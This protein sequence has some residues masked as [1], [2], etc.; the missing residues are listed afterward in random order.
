MLRS[1][2]KKVSSKIL[3]SN[4][5]GVLA[6]WILLLATVIIIPQGSLYSGLLPSAAYAQQSE[7][8]EKQQSQEQDGQTSDQARDEST[9]DL[10]VEIISP[11]GTRG[12][13]PATFEFEANVTGGTEPYTLRWDFDDGSRA[14]DKETVEHTFDEAG[15]YNVTLNATDADDQTASDSLKIVI[16]AASAQ[17]DESSSAGDL[18]GLPGVSDV[19]GLEEG[20]KGLPGLPGLGGTDENPP[21]GGGGTDEN[22]PSGGG[23]TDENPPSDNSGQGGADKFGIDEIYPTASNGPVWYI[24]EVEDPTTDGYFYYGMYRTTTVE[25]IDKGVWEV[26]ALS[27]T[28]EHGIRMHVD[29]PSGKWKNEE[30]TGYFYY[31]QGNDQITMIARHGPSYHA[32]GGCEA[33][34]YYALTAADGQVFFK[35]KLY[36]YNGG[37]TKRLAVVNALDDIHN[38]WIGM[39]FVVYDLSNGDVKLEVWID[40]GDMTNNWKKVS[41]LV[42]DG[43]LNV[44]GGDDCGVQSNHIIKDGTRSSYRADD[45]LFDFKKLSVREIQP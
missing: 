23:G 24:K 11:N 43:G 28:Q 21:S 25:N 26:N 18:K 44:E 40:Q 20:L 41:E 6:L 17:A 45:S 39:K 38:K 8:E 42:D 35:K 31:K 5:A 3:K 15:T 12:V 7:D 22:P 29:S 30:M 4:S 32:N 27:G 16:K 33:Y 36:H 9:Q 1:T 13:A 14:S 19:P 37:Y 34:G 2:R 10:T